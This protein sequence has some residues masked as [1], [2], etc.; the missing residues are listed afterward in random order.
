LKV[1]YY[2]AWKPL[3]TFYTNCQ[4][5]VGLNQGVS[6]NPMDFPLSIPLVSRLDYVPSTG[7]TNTD[8][9]ADSANRSDLAVL[10]AGFQSAGRGRS[11]RE[12]LAP[13]GSSIFASILLRPARAL[14]PDAFGWL[15]LLAGLSM[16]RSISQFIPAETVSV[17]W[18]NDVLVAGHKI[19][20]VLS[21]LLPDFS[22]VVIGAGVNLLQT[23][24]ELP[25]EAATSLGIERAKYGQS[26]P[27][28]DAVLAAYL[29]EL[30]TLYSA[31]VEAG[32][33]ADLS[34]LRAAVTDRCGSI[35]RRVRAIM[36]GDQELIGTAVGI[37]EFGRILIQPDGE[38]ELF[39]VSAGDIVHLR[40]N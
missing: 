7:S 36:P 31:F 24:A 9:I 18:P 2:E 12:W 25:I 39:A 20:G 23:Q 10:V 35:G 38:R 3:L 34:G 5:Q 30:R 21:E 4:N 8:L 29:A 6:L 16:A 17:K 37:D 14:K 22:G 15:P 13:E 26:A 32:G 1:N 27:A 40:H 11:G 28:I 33:D 19:S